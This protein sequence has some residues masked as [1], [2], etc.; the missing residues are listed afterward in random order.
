M[1]D[2]ATV[3]F[4]MELDGGVVE[5]SGTYYTSELVGEMELGYF[6]SGYIWIML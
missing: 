5:G 3:K 4:V 2:T 1:W 6:N